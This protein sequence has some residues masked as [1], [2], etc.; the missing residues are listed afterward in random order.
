[1]IED[2]AKFTPEFSQWATQFAK[3]EAID[4]DW[5]IIYLGMFGHLDRTRVQILTF[6]SAVVS[7][8]PPPS[9]KSTRIDGNLL[10]Y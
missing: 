2:D 4:R 3:V 7:R 6:R 10:K 1:M 5:D 8:Y 9:P